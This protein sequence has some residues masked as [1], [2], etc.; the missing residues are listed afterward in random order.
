MSDGG[1]VLKNR[2]PVLITAAFAVLSLASCSAASVEEL[3]SPPRLDGEQTEIYAALKEYTNGDIILKYPKI[4]QYRSAFVVRNIDDEPTDEA[5]VF[6]EMPNL[7]DGSSLRMNFL[8]KKDGKWMSVYDLAASGSE[9]ESVRFEDLGLNSVTL[10]VNYLMQSTSDRFTSVMTYTNGIPQELI[11]IRNIYMDIF[12]ANN[13]GTK[14]LFTVT[15]ERVT[16]QNIAGIFAALDGAFCQIGG[17]PL[18]NGLAGIKSV[19]CGNCDRL[20]TYTIFIDYTFSDGSSGTDAVLSGKNGF[21]VSPVTNPSVS[22]RTINT[23]T[24]AISCMDIDYDGIIEIPSTV[25]FP[26]YTE[27]PA[28]EQVNMTVWKS[29]ERFGTLIR[30]KARSFV[31]TKGDYI[32]FF[33]EKWESVTASVSISESTVVFNRYDNTALIKGEELLKI[34][35]S[36]DENTSKFKDK[37]LIYLGKSGMTGYNYYAQLTDSRL[38]LTENEIKELFRFQ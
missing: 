20:G 10:V 17:A 14:D 8:D 15:N 3:L 27:T 16:G 9:V 37:D 2:I 13:D 18:N 4:G 23:Y 33:P 26:D 29:L 21:F 31:G 1:D 5:I 12:D 22:Y 19:T 28:A 35:G 38:S 36:S 32:F 34:Y 24:P 25:P 7:S 30:E 6:Y 11:N